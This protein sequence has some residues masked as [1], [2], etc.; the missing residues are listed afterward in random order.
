M[1]VHK[2]SYSTAVSFVYNLMHGREEWVLAQLGSQHKRVERPVRPVLPDY[3]SVSCDY[4]RNGYVR[5]REKTRRQRNG[6]R[7][8]RM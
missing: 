1:G 5:R 8:I 2:Q 3:F 7:K 6:Y 4:D